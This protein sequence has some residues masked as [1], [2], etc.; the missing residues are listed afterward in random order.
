MLV[1]H[2]FQTHFVGRAPDVEILVIKAAGVIRFAKL[3]W[4]IDAD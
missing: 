3:V 1:Q 4:Q 2:N